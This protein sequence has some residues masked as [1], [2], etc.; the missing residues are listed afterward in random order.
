MVILVSIKPIGDNVLFSFSFWSCLKGIVKHLHLLQLHTRQVRAT[1]F[2]MNTS[3]CLVQPSMVILTGFGVCRYNLALISEFLKLPLG[4]FPSRS[5]K[6][7]SLCIK[8]TPNIYEMS[9][10]LPFEPTAIAFQ[11]APQCLAT[12]VL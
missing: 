11:G 8:H 9:L 6:L 4:S 2:Q 7:W 3:V 1:S 10:G 12:R 5:F